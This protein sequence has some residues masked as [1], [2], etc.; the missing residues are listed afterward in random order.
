LYAVG[1]ISVTGPQAVES[2]HKYTSLLLLLLLLFR[3]KILKI[4]ENLHC[5]NA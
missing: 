5:K 1:A 2:E 4:K 3:K